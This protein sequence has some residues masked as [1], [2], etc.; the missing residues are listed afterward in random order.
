MDQL[1]GRNWEWMKHKDWSCIVLKLLPFVWCKHFWIYFSLLPKDTVTLS[2][3]SLPEVR[4]LCIKV[5]EFMPLELQSNAVESFLNSRQILLMRQC[6]QLA[7]F[8]F[9][10]L[11][12]PDMLMHENFKDFAF[13]ILIKNSRQQNACFR[14]VALV[15]LMDYF[16]VCLDHWCNVS[17]C[18]VLLV[19]WISFFLSQL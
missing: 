16:R 8:V 7:E 17:S 19:D 5:A 11:L 1:L 18:L 6:K 12:L 13:W 9:V 4:C 15:A 10:E 3:M 2:C 14:C